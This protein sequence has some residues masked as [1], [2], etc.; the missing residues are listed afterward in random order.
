[1]S[2]QPLKIVAVGDLAFNGRYHRLLDRHG[3]EYPLG[4]VLPHWCDADLRFGN[5]ESP[6]TARPKVTPSKLTLRGA[7]HAI[8]ALQYARFDFV[9]VANNHMM[10]YGPEGLAE[11]CDKLD[12]A[13]IAH[14]GAGDNNGAACAPA[15]LNHNGHT[16]G[17]LA[18]CDVWQVS[19]LYARER[20]PGVAPLRVSDCVAQIQELRRQ[21]DWVIVQL[22]WG[23][24]MAQM[25][26]PEQR[27]WARSLVDAGADLVLGHHPHVLQPAEIVDGVPVFYS[28][29][30]F[31]FSDMFWSG[32]NEKDEAFLAKMKLHPLSRK[33]GWTEII[34][35]K[36]S[37]PQVR[38]RPASLT[39]G[40]A[41]VP[42]DSAKR[43]D[44]WETLNSQL[45]GDGYPRAYEWECERAKASQDALDEWCSLWSRLE[46]KLFGFGLFPNAALGT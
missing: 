28:L 41:V 20:S 35:D 24:E 17:L 23:Q 15:I 5:L 21:V 13:G 4:E 18:Y 12:V 22:H 40:L 6:L 43:L 32:R 16:I 46:S 42:D 34:L 37:P 26:S 10:D 36:Q 7:P 1:M 29:G 39:R 31:L 38:F 8:D 44:E 33:T 14:A 30:D 2:R 3:P 9:A 45:N 25:P 19:P 11:T 27:A